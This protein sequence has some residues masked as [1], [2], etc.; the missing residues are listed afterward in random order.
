MI[1]RTAMGIIFSNMHDNHLGGLT[2]G[3][4][5][6]SVPFGGR[7]RLVD[8][9]LSSLVNS[10]VQEVGVIAKSH[11]QSLMDHLGS[12]REWDLARKLG[13][14]TFFPPYSSGD[15]Q[16]IYAGRLDALS[17]VAGY[18]RNCRS[19]YVIL[20]DCDL[21]A[22]LD[23][24]KIIA[25]HEER[26]AEIT[27]AYRRENIRRAGNENVAVFDVGQDGRVGRVWISPQTDDEENIYLNVAVMKRELL[28]KIV[29][30]ARSRNQRSFTKDIL[31][32]RSDSMR[33]YGYEVKSCAMR[34]NSLQD[35]F[36]TSMALLRE[37]VRQA[38]FPVDRPVLTRV[39]DQVPAKYGL[40]ASVENSLVAD[41]CIIEGAVENSIIFRGAKIGRGAV[42]R[43]S[44]IMSGAIIGD[45]AR[46]EYVVA[47]RDATIRDTRTLVGYKT[48][49][50]FIEKKSVI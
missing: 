32:E 7:Y 22:N 44:I 45:G 23:F 10:G 20:A 43:N 26:D 37:P 28:E 2:H 25:F 38:L 48:Y 16:G 33:I 39:R 3:R 18:I 8:F 46:L 4:T 5:T 34:I 27:L 1:K 31:I 24:Q 50:L 29:S 35:Y 6:G 17:G 15:N 12:G 14:L 41:G 21:I 47:D 13:G 30:E 40:G 42:I 19:E 36:D 49:P 11:Y 9:V